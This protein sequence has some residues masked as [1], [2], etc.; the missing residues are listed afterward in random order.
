MSTFVLLALFWEFGTGKENFD[1]DDE[2]KLKKPASWG[3]SIV[4]MC[5]EDL[6]IASDIGAWG[7][8]IDE[9]ELWAVL[10]LENIKTQSGGFKIGPQILS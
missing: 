3:L 4:Q 1:S 7:P 5:T 10:A 9:G 2:G 8:W 6:A